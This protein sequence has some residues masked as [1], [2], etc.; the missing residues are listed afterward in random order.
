M[1][2]YQVKMK[3]TGWGEKT[4]HM[5][6]TFIFANKVVAENTSCG[7]IV[8]KTSVIPPENMVETLALHLKP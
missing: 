4:F 6:Y 3:N 8:S 5:I 7:V 1:K 2:E